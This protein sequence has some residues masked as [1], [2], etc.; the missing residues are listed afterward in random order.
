MPQPAVHSPWAR[1][2]ET[3]REAHRY[4]DLWRFLLCILFYQAGITA[5]IALAAIY[6]EQA[7]KFTTQET[8]TLILVVNITAAIGAFAFGYLQDA[9]G[10]VRSLALT[11]VGWIV[12]VL[13]AG[14]SHS[15]FS[16]WIA[17]NLAG[18]LF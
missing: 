4:R 6:A 17:A 2:R 7:M 8:I 18:Q 16:F 5:V 9:I 1:L 3:M 14:F 15:S 10:H 12:M 13:I 11:L